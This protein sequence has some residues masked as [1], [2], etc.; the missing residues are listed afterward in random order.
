[1]NFKQ[2]LAEILKKDMAYKGISFD[3]NWDDYTVCLNYIEL[4]KRWF[5]SNIPYK[6]VYSKELLAKISSLTKQEQD[7]IK[8]IEKSLIECKSVTCY[9]SKLITSTEMK[10]SDF[11]LKNWDIYH[12]HLEK[13]SAVKCNY[14][15][16]NLLFFQLKGK[17]IH[18]IDVRK[19]P[20]GSEWFVR[21]LLEIIYNNWPWLLRYLNGIKSVV[22]ISNEDMYSLSKHAVGAINFHGKVLMPTNIGVATSGHSSL[23]VGKACDIFNNLKAYEEWLK[24]NEM[25]IRESIYKQTKRKTTNQL[26]YELLIENDCFIAYEKNTQSKIE[27][28]ECIL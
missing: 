21:D 11:F 2:D 18:F 16:P 12:L 7:A 10:K 26:E 24:N 4:T 8:D 14:T 27:L 20:K 25:E 15:M 1:M 6:V 22:D 5:N 17:I 19:H 3:S 13:L 9:M 28:F 23:S